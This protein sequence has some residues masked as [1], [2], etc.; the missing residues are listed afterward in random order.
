MKT[1]R[2]TA[3]L[4]GA[5]IV[6]LGANIAVAHDWWFWHQHKRTLG[7]NITAANAVSAEAARADWSA[8]YNVMI[9]PS[10][11]HHSDISVL[12]GDYGDTGWGGL[13]EVI[14]YFN[15][16]HE[17]DALGACAQSFP[18]ITHAHVRLNTFYDW[19][20]PPVAGS[21]NDAKRGVFCQEIGHALG[22]DHSPDGCMGKGYFAGL[23]NNEPTSNVVTGHSDGDVNGKYSSAPLGAVCV[24]GIDVVAC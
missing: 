13:A 18:G 1:K 2:S 11:A 17:F 8:G 19:G 6:L 20:T 21:A 4:L 22:L 7:I 12:D 24:P 3:V 16:C 5:V 10:V 15:H 14:T 9:L 23:N